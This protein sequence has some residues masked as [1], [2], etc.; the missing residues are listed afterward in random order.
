MVAHANAKTGTHPVK[1]NGHGKRA[2]TEHEQRRESSAVEKRKG[3]TVGP[4]YLLCFSS[5]D[6]IAAHETVQTAAS[7]LGFGVYAREYK[8]ITSSPCQ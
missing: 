8:L 2:P 3:N 1:E 6:A 4:I 7:L 5:A